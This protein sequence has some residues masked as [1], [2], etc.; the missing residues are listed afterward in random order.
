MSQTQGHWPLLPGSPGCMV[1][2]TCRR[3]MIGL[4]G[5]FWLHLDIMQPDEAASLFTR[6]AGAE[7]SQDPAAIARVVRMC[8]YLPLAIQLAGSR[9]RHHPA[10]SI[11]TLMSRFSHSQPRLGEIRVGDREMAGSLKLPTA[12]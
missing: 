6:I 1:L 10:W 4:P 11:A 7:R 12:I 2:I 5:I 3:R 8:G 9:F